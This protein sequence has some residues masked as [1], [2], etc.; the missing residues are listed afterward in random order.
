MF[1]VTATAFN[2]DKGLETHTANFKSKDDLVNAVEDL[3][4]DLETG[5]CINIVVIKDV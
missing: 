2:M 1:Y 4:E 5:D 3:L